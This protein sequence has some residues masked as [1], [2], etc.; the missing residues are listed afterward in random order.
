MT[1]D[2]EIIESRLLTDDWSRFR[3][4]NYFFWK[5]VVRNV[6]WINVY[7]YLVMELLNCDFSDEENRRAKNYFKM[8]DFVYIYIYIWNGIVFFFFANCLVKQISRINWNYSVIFNSSEIFPFRS[9]VFI[10]HS[11]AGLHMRAN[12]HYLNTIVCST[13]WQREK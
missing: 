12:Y 6:S 13:Y 7:V 9:H 11:N 5:I 4:M 2:R 1:E 3:S 8:I 10:F